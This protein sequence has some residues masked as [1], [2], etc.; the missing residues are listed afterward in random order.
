M[1]VVIYTYRSN[2]LAYAIYYVGGPTGIVA[3]LNDQQKVDLAKTAL[4]LAPEVYEEG[5]T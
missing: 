1:D 2:N 5:K 3:T 4:V